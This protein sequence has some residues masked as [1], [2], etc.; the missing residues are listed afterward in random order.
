VVNGNDVLTTNQAGYPTLGANDGLIIIQP[1]DYL[2]LPGVP[3]GYQIA[4][5]QI[6]TSTEGIGSVANQVYNFNGALNAFDVSA[7][8]FGAATTDNDVIK[9]TNIGAKVTTTTN[10][11]AGR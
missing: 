9:I 7:A 4:G 3:A 5:M 6:T 10:Q 1:N 2:N 8:S 11:T